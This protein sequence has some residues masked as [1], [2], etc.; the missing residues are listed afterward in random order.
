MIETPTLPPSAF[1]VDAAGRQISPPGLAPTI[2]NLVV[3]PKW[4]NTSPAARPPGFMIGL[5]PI[6]DQASNHHLSLGPESI[7]HLPGLS[8]TTFLSA[9]DSSMTAMVAR[10]FP[11]ISCRRRC[12]HRHWPRHRLRPAEINAG[13]LAVSPGFINMMC[14]AGRSLIRRPLAIGHS[15]G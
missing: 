3:R 14:W 15:P 11:P 1:T 2:S 8:C 4:K 12:H 6:R 13:G 7:P 10:R 5:W 9:T